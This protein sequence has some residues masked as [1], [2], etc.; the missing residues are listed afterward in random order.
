[1]RARRR[2][3]ILAVLLAAVVLAAL[4]LI[5]LLSGDRE[6]IVSYFEVARLGADGS[7][8][9]EE[10]I[11]YAFGAAASDRHGIFRVIPGLDP[12]TASASSPTAPD[13]LEVV[14]GRLRIGDPDVTVSGTHRYQ[15]GYALD[16][17]VVGDRFAWNV[18]GGE[19]DVSVESV[20]AH[21]VSDRELTDV[22]CDQGLFGAT[23]GCAA[24]Q[25]GPRHVVVEAGPVP[26]GHALTLYATLGEPVSADVDVPV[27]PAMP[28]ETGAPLAA[29]T[30]LG[31]VAAAAAGLVTG[32]ALRRAGREEAPAGWAG[33][34]GSVVLPGADVRGVRAA[35]V[36]AEALADAAGPQVAPPRALTPAQGG[37]LLAE[38][39]KPQHQAAWLLGQAQQGA[40]ALEGDPE[41]PTLRWVG[42]G[43]A[44]ESIPLL[45]M[46]D[47]RPSIQLGTHDSHFERGWK[48][49]GDQLRSWR[50]SSGLWSPAGERRRWW[51]L[52]IG[53]GLAVIG[54]GLAAFLAYRWSLGSPSVLQLALLTVP[55]GVGAGLVARSWEL[56]VLTPEGAQLY[57]EVEAFRR[58]L[59]DSSA[60][61]VS[62]AAEA[63]SMHDHLAWAVALGESDAWRAA[64][65]RS[66]VPSGVGWDPATMLIASS[67]H[68]SAVQ[69]A[70]APSSSSGGGGGGGAGGGG[71]GGGG[72]SW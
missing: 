67:L 14:G 9:V 24:V 38:R 65:E 53:I 26:A 71:G 11:D 59:H 44:A 50:T 63:G 37:V 46:F 25:L 40:V 27:V 41:E 2:L 45:T 5:G 28:G 13:D 58:H 20:E 36:D 1:M 69:T 55:S 39:V 8:R 16:T 31:W 62:A 70:T 32:R 52:G 64:V 23:G 34:G 51:A 47:R 54:A 3:S 68:T 56:R 42:G 72:G 60:A 57:A 29:P 17:L 35:R 7:A 61:D 30:L 10:T 18:V 22:T 15:L 43:G 4:V 6:R 12:S 19:W 33:G 48:L 21:V 66:G 49:V